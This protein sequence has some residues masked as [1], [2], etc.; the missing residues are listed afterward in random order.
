MLFVETPVFTSLISRALDDDQYRA[1]QA[2]L[3]LRPEQGPVIKG[4][5]RLRKFHLGKEGRGS[6]TARESREI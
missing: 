2:A 3:L 5:G 6:C 4:S 1:L